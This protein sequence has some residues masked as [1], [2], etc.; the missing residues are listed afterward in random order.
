M[1][2]MFKLG[3][4]MLTLALS[5]FACTGRTAHE[6]SEKGE[7][8]RLRY[9]ENLTITDY[10]AYTVVT[11]RNPWDTLKTLHTY[12]LV[13][14][15][16][17]LPPQ[18]PEGTLIRTPLRHAV[19]YSSVHCGLLRELGAE[20]AIGGVCDVKYIKLPELRKAVQQGRVADCGDGMNPDVERIINLHPDAVLLSPFENSGG[21][22]R[23]EKLGVPLIECADYMETS[24]RGRAEWMK[25]YGRLFGAEAKA[26]S[27]FARVDS[28]YQSLKDS[29]EASAVRMSVFCE[30]KNGAAWYVPGGHSTTGRILHDA[31]SNY[32]F[33]DD[34]HSGSVPLAFE[35]VFQRAGEADIWLIKYHRPKDMTY[36][37]LQADY[38]AYAGFKAFRE[39]RVYGCNTAKAAFYEETPFH[40]ERLL[41]DLMQ[42]LHPEMQKGGARRY[43]HELKEE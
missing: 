28:I 1:K 40:P 17:A 9:A 36:S 19:V 6:A 29:A 18:L 12:V 30:L 42:I 25:F 24:A 7:T 5:G 10:P 4:W 3:A 23:V 20:N 8:Q 41:E 27:L 26:D 32:A 34:A 22:G 33:A 31:G 35:T 15:S 37:D 13:P 14:D 21:Y 11:L 16:G 39:R 38:A 43:F 2:N